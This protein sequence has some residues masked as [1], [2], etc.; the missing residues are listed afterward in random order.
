VKLAGV[1]AVLSTRGVAACGE[2]PVI[3]L[4]GGVGYRWGDEFNVFTGCDLGP[5]SEARPE[6]I[7]DGFTVRAAGVTAPA[8]TLRGG[9][10]SAGIMVSGRGGAPKVTIV[11]AKGA[12]V[13]DATKESLT[14][15]AMVAFDPNTSTTNILWKAPPKGTYLVIAA[16]GSPAIAKVRQAVDAGPQHVR[17]SVTG[18]ATHRRL[19]WTV[20]PELAKGQELTLGEAASLDGAGHDI[21]T[22]RK[23]S[24]TLAFSPQDGHGE[25]RVITATIVTDGL[26]RPSTVAARFTAPRL[27][28]PDR[29]KGLTLTRQGRA[30]TL[31]W[32]PA[33]GAAPAGGWR[34]AL[35]A[36]DLKA[37]SAFVGAKARTYKVADVPAGLGV[38]A[39]V[40]GLA[41]NR[42]AG[43]AAR[44]KLAVGATRSGGPTGAAPAR[45]VAL[46]AR[47]SGRKLVVR[48]RPGA[49]RPKGY[50]V[51]VTVGRGAPVR[52]ATTARR[53]TVT[54]TG[55]PKGKAAVAVEVRAVRLG[56]GL[57][58]PV[59]LRGR[60]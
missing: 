60:R 44:V 58:A 14:A 51:L 27:V 3:Q 30:V 25:R 1:K 40:S 5:Y 4:G 21:T 37:V 16:E 43:P 53:P 32:T 20:T 28:T 12:T 36:G 24:G 9:L 42:A 15:R 19:Q 50:T 23:S 26:P 35:N 46:T 54:V 18:P 8:V 47:R 7:P 57:S 31:R 34:V 22:T 2:I 39:T 48:W 10:R 56:G 49:E 41:A 52:L 38:S 55:L 45:P 29:P 59:R 33:A 11:D 17:V 6:G 13:L